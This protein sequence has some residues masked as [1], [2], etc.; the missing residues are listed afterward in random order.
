MR[1]IAHGLLETADGVKREHMLALVVWLLDVGSFRVG[2][3]RY[4]RDDGHVGLTTLR[5]DQ[6]TVRRDDSVRFDDVAMSGKHRRLTVRDPQA[7]RA[8]GPLKRRRDGPVELL[9][10]RPAVT[11]SNGRRVQADDVNNEGL[12]EWEPDVHWCHLCADLARHDLEPHA[13]NCLRPS[14]GRR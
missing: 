9:V 14:L 2:W 1:A 4:A 11:P 3:D 12:S 8:L 13:A 10:F 7:A 6:V 5:R